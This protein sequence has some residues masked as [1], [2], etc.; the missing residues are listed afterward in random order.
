MLCYPSETTHIEYDDCVSR[1][2]VDTQTASPRGQK[3][4]EILRVLCI[5]VRNRFLALLRGDHAVQPLV[6]ISSQRHVIAEDI[7]HAHHLAEDEDSMTVLSQTSEQ[8]VK[9]DHLSAAHDETFE[10]LFRVV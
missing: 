8:F 6:L 10:G 3:K 4:R 7:K 1:L 5:E 2:Q 9:K